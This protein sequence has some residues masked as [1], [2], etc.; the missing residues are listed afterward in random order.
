MSLL[1]WSPWPPVNNVPT[2]CLPTAV[3]V[4][5]RTDAAVGV[6]AY[7]GGGGAGGAAGA[8][9]PKHIIK[10]VEFRMCISLI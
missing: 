10:P 8:E 1:T 9:A 4:D 5:A 6:C 3:A 2:V 7:W